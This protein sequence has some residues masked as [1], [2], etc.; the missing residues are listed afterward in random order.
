MRKIGII[1]VLSLMALALAAVPALAANPHFQSGPTFTD[2]GTRV[3]ATG[4]IAGLGNQD[5]TVEVLATG[6]GT[7]T[8]TNP[9]GNVAPGQTQEINTSGSDSDIEVKNGKATFSVTTEPPPPPANAKAAGCP[10]NKWRARITDVDFT[11]ATIN[12]F[13]G[14]RLVFTQTQAI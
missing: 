6:T 12:V 10:N 13:Q 4:T 7:V 14:G 3:N 5:V 8:C 9:A 1:A 11:S 2:L